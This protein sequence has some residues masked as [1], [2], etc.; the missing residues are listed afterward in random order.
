MVRFWL[1]AR[2]KS[3]EGGGQKTIGHC[4]LKILGGQTPFRGQKSFGGGAPL[5]SRKPGFDLY[6]KLKEQ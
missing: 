5:C 2:K 6:P 3:E 4:L 1:S